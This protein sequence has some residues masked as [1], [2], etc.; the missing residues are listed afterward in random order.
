MIR[1]TVKT[2]STVVELGYLYRQHLNLGKW[3]RSSNRK[4]GE[5]PF[6]AVMLNKKWSMEE[7]FNIHMLIFRQVVSV[8]S[9]YISKLHFDIPGWIGCH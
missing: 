5:N 9:I 4:S 1:D 2:G 8:S 6:G 3:Y 7:E